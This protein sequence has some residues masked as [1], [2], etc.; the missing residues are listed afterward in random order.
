MNPSHIERR[1]L[2]EQVYTH[3]KRMILSGELKGGERIPEERIAREFGV[4]R[5]PIREA[6]RRLEEYG[7]VHIEPRSYAEVVAIELAEADQIA[8]VR[9]ALEG[10]CVRLLAGHATEPDCAAL[11]QLT[12]DCRALIAAGDLGAVFEKDSQ[13]HLEL[14]RRAGN[15]CLREFLERLDARVQLCRLVKCLTLAHVSAA[16]GQHDEVIAALR[17]A[18]GEA[19]AAVLARHALNPTPDT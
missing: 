3:V 17:R 2:A 8:Q 5:T 19:A 10:L 7:L 14:A 13:F 9:A 18:D 11:E 6:L 16:L 4:S 1:S 15:A 12:A